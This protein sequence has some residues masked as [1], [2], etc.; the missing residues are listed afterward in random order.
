MRNGL[1]LA[2]ANFD[3]CVSGYD[4]LPDRYLSIQKGDLVIFV[5]GMRDHD[6]VYVATGRSDIG[7]VPA[8]YVVEI[9]EPNPCS[10]FAHHLVLFLVLF[11]LLLPLLVFLLFLFLLLLLLLLALEKHSVL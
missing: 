5:A 1:G 3:P 7:W 6:W 9:D 2:I 10:S 4:N 8:T 11:L